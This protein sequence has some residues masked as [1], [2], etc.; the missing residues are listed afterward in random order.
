MTESKIHPVKSREAGAAKPQFNGVKKIKKRDGRIVDFEPEKIAKAIYKATEAV[1]EPNYD[2]AKMLAQK[3]VKF[4]EKRISPKK[5]PTVEGVQD[6]VEK[7][8]IEEGKARIAKAYILYRQKRT[9]IRKEKQQILQK[10]EID[11]VDKKFD[12]NALRVL[13]SRYLKKDSSGKIIESPKQLFERVAIHT[14]LPSLFYDPRIFRKKKI[15]SYPFQEFDPQKYEGKFQIGSFQLNQFHLKALKILYDRFNQR[16]QIKVSWAGFLKILKKGEFGSY[17]DEIKQYYNLMAERKFLPNTPALANF[18]NFLGMGSACFVISIED[19]IESIMDALKKASIIFKSGGGVG[20][21]FS[22]LRPEGSFVKSTGGVASGPISFMTLFDK[23]TDVVKQGGLRRGASIGILDSDHPDIEKFI[24]AKRG[25]LQLRNFNIS[26]FIKS[27]FW[28]YYKNNKPYPLVNPHNGQIAKYVDPK[29]LFNLI[30]YQAW[31]SAEPGVIFEEHINKY[32]P[33]FKSFGS[34]K[35][36]NPCGEVPLFQNE[37][38]NLGSINVWAF[39]K[40]HPTNGRKKRVEFDWEEF[41][42]TIRVATRFLDNVVDVNEYPLPEIESRTLK[43]RKVGLGIMGLGDLLYDLEIPYNSQEGLNWMEKLTEFLNY[44]SKIASIELAKERGVFPYYGQSFYPEGKL[45]FRGAK[46]KKSWNL[47][48][49]KIKEEIKKH[50]IRNTHTICAAPTGSLSMIAGCSSGIEPVYSLVY[51][52]KV[53]IGSFYYVNSVFER[54]M[55]REGLFDEDLIKDVSG[56]EGSCQKINYF[57]QRLK[58]IFIT[59]MDM[60]AKEH[61]LALVSLQKW[62]DASISKTINFPAE[63]TVEEMKRA[64]LLAHQLGCKD[65]TVFRNKSIKGVLEA[66]KRKEEKRKTPKLISLEDVKVKG[67]SIYREAGVHEDS[68]IGLGQEFRGDN[69]SN[70]ELC[71]QCKTPLVETEG[72]KKCPNC[73]WAPCSI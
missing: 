69:N 27:N 31:E 61:I 17:Q 60:S 9:E 41:E 51:E 29:N 3:V 55:K 20:Y 38:C 66:G 26:V 59:A 30:V 14:C 34:I 22:N 7:I 72:C 70:S 36:T 5:I 68:E 71:P 57:P 10:I 15:S 37:S 53:T 64:Y 25:N 49:Q 35:A 11:E 24:M 54:V 16:G 32:N 52:K 65:L 56:W 13:C 6:T 73:G 44:Y 8:L 4:L 63:A 43:T 2:L 42:K 21:N 45:P 46:D 1:G 47:D 48:W 40:T 62:T 18:G 50:G 33:L 58:K 12:I 39:I 67:P 28:E 19:S 23:M